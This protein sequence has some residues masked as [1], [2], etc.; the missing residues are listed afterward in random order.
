MGEE[1]KRLVEKIQDY[2]RIGFLNLYIS[3]FLYAGSMIPKFAIFPEK[4]LLLT[5]AS[6]AFS[7]LA[8]LCYWRMSSL[9]QKL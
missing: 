6:F 5:Y 8:V 3:A 7:S 9:N 4:V 2:R 1:Q